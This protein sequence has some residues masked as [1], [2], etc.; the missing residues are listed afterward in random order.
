VTVNMQNI[1]FVAPD[2]SDDVT[3]PLGASVEWVNLDSVSH[4]ATSDDVPAGGNAFDSG[5]LS[6]NET[7]VFTPNVTG[8]WVYHCEVHPTQ[9]DGATITVT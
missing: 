6:L 2:G 1:A 4:T 7:F 5:L 8:T 3:I 9:M